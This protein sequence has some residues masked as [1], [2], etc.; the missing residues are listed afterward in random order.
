MVR[1]FPALAAALVLLSSMFFVAVANGNWYEG[2]IV[3]TT[4]CVD[5]RDDYKSYDTLEPG[6]M[7]HII[8]KPPSDDSPEEWTLIRTDPEGLTCYVAAGTV[9]RVIYE[10]E[11]PL[12]E[13]TVMPT[14]EAPVELP[15]EEPTVPLEPTTPA[16]PVATEEALAVPPMV[17]M[18]PAESTE[19]EVSAA[20]VGDA[21][22]AMTTESVASEEE[23]EPVLV[24]Q[25]PS[26]GTG[27][28]ESE[29]S[30][31]PLSQALLWAVALAV[32]II[33]TGYFAFFLWA[34]AA[35]CAERRLEA[36]RK[37]GHA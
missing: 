32:G 31:V 11:T 23:N 6:E 5:I 28:D 27:T 2:V 25:L 15:T 37:A 7:V 19:A 22:P 17:E 29:V 30:D 10:E 18:T 34:C 36:R 26:T 35:R 8:E 4:E 14:E 9:Q 33:L 13:A 24:S 3:S 1:I 12:P 16:E 21:A 20:S